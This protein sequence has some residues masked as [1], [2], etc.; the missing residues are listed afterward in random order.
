MT[1]AQLPW[2]LSLV[3]AGHILSRIQLFL[4]GPELVVVAAGAFALSLIQVESF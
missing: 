3:A 2:G 4:L 1:L